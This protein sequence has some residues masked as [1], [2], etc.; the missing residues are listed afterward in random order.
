M[1]NEI[2]IILGLTQINA[3]QTHPPSLK[4]RG[5]VLRSLGEGEQILADFV[6]EVSATIC[7]PRTIVF[8]VSAGSRLW[9]N[10]WAG[11]SAYICVQKVVLK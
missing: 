1:K 10:R 4:L 11:Q 3:N 2:K 9:F 5:I 7:V 6:N 8:I